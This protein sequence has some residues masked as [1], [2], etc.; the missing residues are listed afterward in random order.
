M[1]D[2]G[3]GVVEEAVAEGGSAPEPTPAPAG[4]VDIGK[5]GAVFK[6]PMPQG[7]HI[8]LRRI[9]KAQRDVAV[10]EARAEAAKLAENT[11]ALAEL[12]LADAGEIGRASCRERV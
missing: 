1:S 10:E 5:T 4:G 12:G 6:V 11:V 7:C 8:M 9:S 3:E 2:A